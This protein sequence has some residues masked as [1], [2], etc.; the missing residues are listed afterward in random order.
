MLCCQPEPVSES[1]SARNAQSTLHIPCRLSAWSGQPICMAC[2]ACGTQSPFTL[3]TS[4]NNRKQMRLPITKR[5]LG[6]RIL[7][8]VCCALWIVRCGLRALCCVLCVFCV[9]CA[10]YCVLCAVCS[11]LC[12]VCCALRAIR[13]LCALFSLSIV[14]L[15]LIA[16]FVSTWRLNQEASTESQQKLTEPEGLARQFPII[17]ALLS[18]CC[19]YPAR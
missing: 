6:G 19:C 9:L 11:A 8:A 3:H 14:A 17:L 18:V 16:S 2:T 1:L 12:A 4:R 13:S 10:V 7:C 5:H 15:F